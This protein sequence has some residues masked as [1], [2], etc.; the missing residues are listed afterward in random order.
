MRNI[1]PI[2]L[3]SINILHTRSLLRTE[4][5]RLWSRTKITFRAKP[6]KLNHKCHSEASDPL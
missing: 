5:K 1:K 6:F 4:S 3:S 2:Y